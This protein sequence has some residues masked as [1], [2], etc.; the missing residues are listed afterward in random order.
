MAKYVSQSWFIVTPANN[1][2]FT[3][4]SGPTG[5][6]KLHTS[7]ETISRGTRKA[8]IQLQYISFLYSFHYLN[9]LLFDIVIFCSFE[10]TDGD[11]LVTLNQCRVQLLNNFLE[12]FKQE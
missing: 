7:A 10:L 1:E 2:S 3:S 9:S 12:D 8:E 4:F 5:V 6:F 11:G